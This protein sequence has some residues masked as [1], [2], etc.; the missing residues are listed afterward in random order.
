MVNHLVAECVGGEHEVFG[1]VV[2]DLGTVRVF[3]DSPL[4]TYNRT[5]GS[6][7]QVLLA[8]FHH[9]IVLVVL[10]VRQELIAKALITLFVH[11]HQVLNQLETILFQ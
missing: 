11:I 2:I 3:F 6:S 7:I 9:P 5:L 10:D 1:E 4:V 8:H